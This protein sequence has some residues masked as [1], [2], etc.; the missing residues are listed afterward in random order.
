M[1]NEDQ[2]RRLAS[3]TRA[4]AHLGS[5]PIADVFE[6]AST[7]AGADVL[8]V[9][10]PEEEHG[11]STV[12]LRTGSAVI[13]VGVTR[14][15]MRQRSS[16][17]HELGHFIAGDLST[18]GSFTPG[19]RTDQEVRANAFARHLLL[20]LESVLRFRGEAIGEAELSKLVQ[21]FGVSPAIAAIQLREAGLIDSNLCNA[22]RSKTAYSLAA[23]HGWLNQYRV[24]IEASMSPRAP[25]RLME[26]AATAVQKGIIDLDEAAEWYGLDPAEL[27]DGLGLGL[28][29]GIGPQDYAADTF[30]DDYGIGT[31]LF[32]GTTNS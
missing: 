14:H 28:G 25:Q 15:P 20:P 24:L 26:R 23:R 16:V 18:E 30:E 9:E 29:L 13:A 32:G 3:E 7:V 1:S 19:A 17:A 21:E 27:R 6:F 5:A 8:S 10:A 12:S 2:G 4:K 22:W 11:L 31:P